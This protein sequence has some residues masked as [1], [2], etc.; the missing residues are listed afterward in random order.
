MNILTLL[1]TIT[2]LHKALPKQVEQ[3]FGKK[4]KREARF[5]KSSDFPCF[6]FIS[7]SSNYHHD[8]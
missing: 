1:I 2:L 3:P 5:I 7:Y 8:T 6:C 4:E